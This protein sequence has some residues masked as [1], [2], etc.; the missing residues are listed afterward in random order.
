MARRIGA[1]P[2][3]RLD[4]VAVVDDRTWDDAERLERP[5]RALGA[6]GVGSV[7]LIDNLLLPWPPAQRGE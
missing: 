3:A 4:Y 5:S 6:M 7:R 2:L 1:E